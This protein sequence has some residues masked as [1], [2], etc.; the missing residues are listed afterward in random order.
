MNSKTLIRSPY[1]ALITP[2]N[3]FATLYVILLVIAVLFIILIDC[4]EKELILLVIQ[5]SFSLQTFNK[6]GNF[7]FYH[8]ENS[9]G[10]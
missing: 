8:L 9:F 10:Q 5:I 7:V 3:N 2:F 4:I 6:S 1:I